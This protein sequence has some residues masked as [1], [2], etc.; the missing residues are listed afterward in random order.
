MD[1][2]EGTIEQRRN[3]GN[4]EHRV[5][6][7]SVEFSKSGDSI[8]EL[9]QMQQVIDWHIDQPERLRKKVQQERK[10]KNLNENDREFNAVAHWLDRYYE[11]EKRIEKL[12]ALLSYGVEIEKI[13]EKAKTSEKESISNVGTSGEKDNA[14]VTEEPEE[15]KETESTEEKKSTDGRRKKS[16]NGRRKKSSTKK[17]ESKK[18]ETKSKSSN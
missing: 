12:K 16:T 3:L 18:E 5:I 7:I 2:K 8:E 15:S 10:M 17:T 1:F 9:I 4:F 13:D 14:V 6:T 11:A